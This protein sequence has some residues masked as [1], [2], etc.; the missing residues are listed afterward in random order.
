[1]GEDPD[2]KVNGQLAPPDVTAP[3]ISDVALTSNPGDD[4]TYVAGDTVQATVTF[5]EDVSVTGAP[6]LELDIGGTARTAEYRSTSGA[7]V[8]FGYT[9]QAG[10]NDADGIAI[11]ANQLTLNGGAIVA[12]SV[13]DAVLT[14]DGVAD[15]LSHLVNAPGGL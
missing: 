14:H 13:H 3:T 9:V 6:Q 5:S 15:D 10:D 1:M 8:M 12:G 4:D 2:H 11:N 7:A